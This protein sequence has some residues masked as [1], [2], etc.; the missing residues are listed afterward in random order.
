MEVATA[1]KNGLFHFDKAGVETIMR[2]VARWY[3]VEVVYEGNITNIA[4]TGKAFRNSTLS[5][6]LHILKLSDIHFKVEGR[7]II[8]GN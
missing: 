7:K 2:Q 4:I 3:D 8:I 5:E 6:M 1:W